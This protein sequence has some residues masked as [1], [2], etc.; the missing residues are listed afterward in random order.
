MLF[1]HYIRAV[2]GWTEQRTPIPALLVRLGRSC[3]QF[4]PETPKR[5]D[6]EDEALSQVESYVA[7]TGARAVNS[8]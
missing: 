7:A 5:P 6:R 1:R 2:P 4:V 3:P 8:S